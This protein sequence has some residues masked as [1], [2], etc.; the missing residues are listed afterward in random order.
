MPFLS[1]HDRIAKA[2][3]ITLPRLSPRTISSRSI[4]G[5]DA[6]SLAARLPDLDWSVLA[7]DAPVDVEIGV[8]GESVF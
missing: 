6:T 7:S 3:D 2:Y 1:G 8:F 4:D 5:I